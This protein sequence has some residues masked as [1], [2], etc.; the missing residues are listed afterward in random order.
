MPLITIVRLCDVVVASEVVAGQLVTPREAVVRPVGD[1]G[2]QM[3]KEGVALRTVDAGV[4]AMVV[5]KFT[6]E[7]PQMWK[8]WA[9]RDWQRPLPL[10]SQTILKR[11]NPVRISAASNFCGFAGDLGFF[12][13]PFDG[14]GS[15]APKKESSTAHITIKQGTIMA[16]MIKSELERL[17]PIKLTWSVQQNGDGFLVPFPSK[18][19]LQRMVAMRI[20]PR[21]YLKKA[22]INVYGVP[23]E[24]RSFLPHWAVGTILGTTLK[25]DMKYMKRMRVVRILVGV[26]DVN[27]IPDTTDIVVGEGVYDIFFKVDKVCKD[28]TYVPFQKKGDD[29]LDDD[30]LMDDVGGM[31]KPNATDTDMMQEANDKAE[32]APPSNTPSCEHNDQAADEEKIRSMVQEA[33]DKAAFDIIDE[34]AAKVVAEE[35]DGTPVIVSFD[36]NE[37]VADETDSE[38]HSVDENMGT[39]VHSGLPEPT[40]TSPATVEALKANPSPLAPAHAQ[41]LAGA[42]LEIEFTPVSSG[43]EKMAS[44]VVEENSTELPLHGLSQEMSEK[45]ASPEDMTGRLHMVHVPV[46]SANSLLDVEPQSSGTQQAQGLG[47]LLD[48]LLDHLLHN[49]IHH[50]GHLQCAGRL[51]FQFCG[52]Q[53]FG[54]RMM[55]KEICKKNGVRANKTNKAMADSL[56]VLSHRRGGIIAQVTAALDRKGSVYMVPGPALDQKRNLRKKDDEEMMIKAQK[57]AAKRNLDKAWTS[58]ASTSICTGKFPAS[59]IKWRLFCFPKARATTMVCSVHRSPPTLVG[60]SPPPT[61]SASS[62]VMVTQHAALP[63]GCTCTDIPDRCMGGV[64]H[65]RP[66]LL[67]DE[68]RLILRCDFNA[69]LKGDRDDLCGFGAS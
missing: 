65:G 22:W 23:Y 9:R 49:L 53:R 41:Q 14:A 58:L 30:E 67:D 3:V 20:E 31:K 47:A 42:M 7:V 26:M 18:V 29:N 68:D 25:V 52:I 36:K 46:G 4:V 17:I 1:A 15:K 39:N 24:I 34:I 40:C 19:E 35:D 32:D 2:R 8:I 64:W 69:E 59:G 16:D 50:P 60:L 21:R 11:R 63:S 38:T 51:L 62:A 45:Q 56:L 12:Q 5:D 6:R 55:R 61:T 54:P 43:V 33:I 57:L 44:E 28:G 13:I 66:V 27:T 37:L 48:S 10:G